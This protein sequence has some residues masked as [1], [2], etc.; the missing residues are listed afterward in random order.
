MFRSQLSGPHLLH[1]EK[2]TIPGLPFWFFKGGADC[3][4]FILTVVVVVAVDV[5]VV[6]KFLLR[7]S[8]YVLVSKVGQEDKNKIRIITSNRRKE[9][10]KERERERKTKKKHCWGKGGGG[11][12]G[13]GGKVPPH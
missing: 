11:L 3:G 4:T 13:G 7:K 6:V 10:E 8:G 5:V 9:E 12:G 1:S 2:R